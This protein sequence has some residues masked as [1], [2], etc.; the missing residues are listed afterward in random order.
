[1]SFNLLFLF[2]VRGMLL[3]LLQL[4]S[5]LSLQMLLRAF[6]VTFNNSLNTRLK[7]QSNSPTSVYYRDCGQCDPKRSVKEK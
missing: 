1:M 6:K 4:V 3:V 7:H 5:N 2:L